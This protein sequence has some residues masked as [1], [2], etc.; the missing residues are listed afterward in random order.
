MGTEVSKRLRS[1]IAERAGRRCEYCRIHEADTSNVHQVDHI[2][3][4]KHRGPSSPFNLAYACVFCNRRKGSDIASIDLDSGELNRLYNP[5]VDA[6]DRHFEL[7]GPVIRPLTNIARM[8][9]QVLGLNLPERV[10]ERHVLQLL[11]RYP[12]K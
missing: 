9:A 3:S 5:R 4:R 8:T 10:E 2:V 12:S 11:G 1:Q 7:D 6:W